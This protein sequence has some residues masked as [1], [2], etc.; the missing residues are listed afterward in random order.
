MALNSHQRHKF[1]R[2]EASRD[3]L[4]LE[5][6]KW[7]FE[8]FSRDISTEDTILFCQNTC[9]TGNN[10]VEMCQAYQDITRLECFID[11]HLFKYA[12]AVM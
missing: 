2:T 11:L 6:W 9:K 1:L 7:C 12:F 10:A 3:I 4:N 8:G 5:S